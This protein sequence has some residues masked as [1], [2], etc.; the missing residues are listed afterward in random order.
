MKKFLGIDVG[1]NSI[2]W[3]V[4]ME[5]EEQAS[6]LGMGAR[7]FNE[8]VNA[9][10][11]RPKNAKRR[12][13]RMARRIISRRARRKR[14][15]LRILLDAGL[16]PNDAEGRGTLFFDHNINPYTL[17]KRALDEPLTL[18]EFGRAIFHLA[19][20][21]GFK[22]NRKA[23]LSKVVEDPDIKAI[24][25]DEEARAA[26]RRAA[27]KSGDEEGVVLKAIADLQRELDQSG[28]RTLGEYLAEKLELGERVRR[29][30]ADDPANVSRDMVEQEFNTIW[31]AQSQYHAALRD[32]RL[33]ALCHRAIFF[34]RPL[35]VQRFLLNRCTLEPT[36]N[37]A[38][39][40][41]IISQSFRIWQT[42]N[43]LTYRLPGDREFKDL[44]H[45]QRELLA[46]KLENT[47]LMSW[48]GIRRHLRLAN[49][50]FNLER[51]E[52]KGLKGNEA[53]VF[54]T[55]ALSE[56]TLARLAKQSAVQTVIRE[57]EAAQQRALTEVE[58]NELALDALVHDVL[59]TDRIDGLL[60]LLR[61]KKWALSAQEAYS[62]ATSDFPTGTMSLSAKAMR[63]ILPHLKRGLRYANARIEAYGPLG[64]LS[65]EGS[66]PTL[67]MPEDPRNPVVFRALNELRKVVNAI[68]R[69]YGPLDG[70]RVELARDLKLTKKQ[71]E[72][73]AEQQ[74]K[75]RRL[76]EQAKAEL[77]KL[78][79]FQR[80]PGPE[81]LEKYRLW[82]ESDEMCPYTG[83]K[84]SLSE[85]FGPNVDVEHIIPYPRCWDDSFLNKTI[86]D[87]TFNRNR[88][89]G[90]TPKECLS[91]QE[92]EA[93]S[94]RLMS[95]KQMKDS[96]RKR[97]FLE[98]NDQATEGFLNRQINDTGHISR[99][100]RQ[101]LAQ[102][103]GETNVQVSTGKSTQLLRKHWGLDTVLNPE[104]KD[105]NDHRHHAVDALVVALTSRAVFQRISRVSGL[106]GNALLDRLSLSGSCPVPDVRTV[107]KPFLEEMVVSHQPNRKVWGELMEATAY[108]KVGPGLY[109]YRKPVIGL[110]ATEIERVRDPQ[111]RRRLQ[112][113]GAEALA[114]PADPRKPVSFTNKHGK[115]VV[116]RSVRLL[117][118]ARDESMVDLSVRHHPTGSNHHVAVFQNADGERRYVVV[119]MFDAAQRVKNGKP[120][121]A[122]RYEKDPSF[123]LLTAW[124][125]GDIVEVD[126]REE[127]FYRVVSFS[128]LDLDSD[129]KLYLLL[130]PHRNAVESERKQTPD[131]AEPW[132]DVL[133]KTASALSRVS[134]RIEIDPLGRIK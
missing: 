98:L 81:D 56:D 51:T 89:K 86:C 10:D 79:A 128:A 132:A 8:A 107:I 22:S 36:R 28:A 109:V 105:R 121:Y 111:L 23:M 129:S 100:A 75:N 60:K 97:F 87:A 85:L 46:D 68:Q 62:L 14:L 131:A 72:A 53:R 6:I 18:E 69:S 21:R 73:V 94:S 48:A 52:E 17:R 123:A 9:K 61:S 71:K 58:Q 116:V 133:V 11:R 120:L 37:V 99:H 117:M 114:K 122:T 115:E 24:L 5:G 39:K 50:E 63:K 96:K 64:E 57:R 124:H 101:Y 25:E 113:I 41:Q 108:G 27:K 74:S 65:R 106:G 119:S 93:L 80:T 82:V 32:L 15:L 26:E 31:D 45:E 104:G 84:I 91:E 1:T 59:H 95:F 49:A 43:N 54:V 90:Q 38:Y 102:L 33:R 4:T 70:I 130:R 29:G 76:N 20:R 16:L 127:R 126:G 55:K 35:K 13:K 88:K 19:Q 44:T 34:Q 30:L 40:G 47:P 112:E 78:E 134:P 125:S 66:T 67:G 118:R 3:A 110:K 103:V 42:I 77:M 7:I 83:R 2:G 12:E 92:Q